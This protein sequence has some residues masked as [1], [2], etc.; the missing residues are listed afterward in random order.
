MDNY[1]IIFQ[2]HLRSKQHNSLKCFLRTKKIIFIIRK[3]NS[4]GKGLF[5]VCLSFPNEIRGTIHSYFPLNEI[6]ILAAICHYTE[7][8]SKKYSLASFTI[9]CFKNSH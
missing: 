2:R 6:Y 5:F 3:K 8:Q 7:N 4:Y 9:Q 1:K